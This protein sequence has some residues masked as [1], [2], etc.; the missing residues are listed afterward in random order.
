VDIYKRAHHNHII[1]QAY[2]NVVGIDE[3]LKDYASRGLF[4]PKRILSD[5]TSE[6]S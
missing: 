2:N 1:H 5:L 6:L 4:K 3:Y